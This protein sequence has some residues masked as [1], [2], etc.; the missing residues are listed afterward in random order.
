[1]IT[2]LPGPPVPLYTLGRRMLHMYPYVPLGG[3]VRIGVAVISY[4]DALHFG[5]TGD[6]DSTPDLDVLRRGVRDGLTELIEA[7]PR[8]VEPR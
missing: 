6:H 8:S 4:Y 3:Q 2:N 1:V 7:V 5:F